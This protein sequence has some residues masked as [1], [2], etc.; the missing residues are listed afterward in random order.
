MTIDAG[1]DAEARKKGKEWVATLDDQPDGGWLVFNAAGR[2]FSLKP[3][4]F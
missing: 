4:T 2:L 3:G 1:D